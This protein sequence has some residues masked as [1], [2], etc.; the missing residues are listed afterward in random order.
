MDYNRLIDL[1]TNLLSRNT[2]FYSEAFIGVRLIA[3]ICEYSSFG[4]PEAALHSAMLKFCTAI[5]ASHQRNNASQ[6]LRALLADFQ[7]CNPRFN[8]LFPRDLKRILQVLSNQIGKVKLLE[9]ALLA[10]Y[11]T[12]LRLQ[13]YLPFVQL[14]QP[15]SMWDEL[16]RL[17]YAPLFRGADPLVP[18]CFIGTILRSC[19]YPTPNQ[20]AALMANPIA[21]W[22]SPTWAVLRSLLP[23]EHLAHVPGFLEKAFAK[24]RPEALDLLEW[25][26]CGPFGGAKWEPPNPDVPPDTVLRYFAAYAATTARMPLLAQRALE[27]L[28]PALRDLAPAYCDCLLG[29]LAESLPDALRYARGMEEL[30]ARQPDLEWPAHVQR[31]LPELALRAVKG[32]V[33]PAHL[34]AA[35]EFPCP[36]PALMARLAEINHP[37]WRKAPLHNTVHVGLFNRYCAVEAPPCCRTPLAHTRLCRGLWWL[38]PDRL[39]VAHPFFFVTRHAGCQAPS[40]A[41]RVEALQECLLKMSAS[42]L[43]NLKAL[44]EKARAAPHQ[45]SYPH[46]YFVQ[47]AQ[48]LAQTAPALVKIIPTPDF[49]AKFRTLCTDALSAPTMEV[50]SMHYSDVVSPFV[51]LFVTLQDQCKRLS[52]PLPLALANEAIRAIVCF[53]S[54]PF[55]HFVLLLS[56]SGIMWVQ[57]RASQGIHLAPL[58]AALEKFV[59][60]QYTPECIVPTTFAHYVLENLPPDSSRQPPQHF[61]LF[62]GLLFQRMQLPPVPVLCPEAHDVLGRVT[63]EYSSFF[64]HIHQ[65]KVPIAQLRVFAPCVPNL[66]MSLKH[67]DSVTQTLGILSGVFSTEPGVP[68]PMLGLFDLRGLMRQGPLDRLV[69]SQLETIA[70]IAATLDDIQLC[71]SL[72]REAAIRVQRE[73]QRVDELKLRLPDLTLEQL[74]PAL[75]EL[76]RSLFNPGSFAILRHFAAHRS[77]IFMSLLRDGL[78]ALYPDAIDHPYAVSD[79]GEMTAKGTPLLQS[80]REDLWQILFKS[81]TLTIMKHQGHFAAGSPQEEMAALRGF[82]PDAD[83]KESSLQLVEE[84]VWFLSFYS[85]ARFI[86]QVFQQFRIRPGPDAAQYQ[87]LCELV[88]ALPEVINEKFQYDPGMGKAFRDLLG[89]GAPQLGQIFSKLAEC[90]ALHKWMMEMV[91][92]GP[93]WRERYEAKRTMVQSRLRQD[94]RNAYDQ[95]VIS[96]LNEWLPILAE[97]FDP[98]RHPMECIGILRE[99]LQPE[100]PQFAGMLGR[101]SNVCV[102][103]SQ[104]RRWFNNDTPEQHALGLMEDLTQGALEL[105]FN[106]HGQSK[107]IGIWHP[108]EGQA[109]SVSELEIVDMRRHLRLIRDS[110][111]RPAT[112]ALARLRFAQPFLSCLP[113]HDLGQ[114]PDAQRRIEDFIQKHD[115]VSLIR[116][117]AQALAKDGHPRL[118]NARLTISLSKLQPD[119]LQTI[120]NNGQHANISWSD[121][122]LHARA[123]HPYLAF[124]PKRDLFRLAGFLNKRQYAQAM[125]LLSLV[126]PHQG[127]LRPAIE[128][129]LARVPFFQELVPN[130]DQWVPDTG[131]PQ[132]YSLQIDPA[133]RAAWDLTLPAG[134]MLIKTAEACGDFLLHLEGA[135]QQT[136]GIKAL[137]FRPSQ[138]GRGFATM[139]HQGQALVLMAEACSPPRN[140]RLGR[141][142]CGL[143]LLSVLLRLYPERLPEHSDLLWCGPETTTEALAL[144]FERAEH[145]TDRCYTVIHAGRLPYDLQKILLDRCSWYYRNRL[146]AAPGAPDPRLV[147]V[148]TADRPCSLS[149]THL[150]PFVEY[151]PSQRLPEADLRARLAESRRPFDVECVTG[152]AGNGKTYHI[153]RNAPNC[154]T[155]PI[156]EDF[157]FASAVEALATLQAKGDD[158]EHYIHFNISGYADMELVNAFF[159]H[160]LVLHAVSDLH[161][162]QCFAMRPAAA[163]R[164]HFL[165]EI[166]ATMQPRVDE[167]PP[168]CGSSVLTDTEERGPAILRDH[169]PVLHLATPSAQLVNADSLP[170]DVSEP[171][172]ALVCKYLQGKRFLADASNPDRDIVSQVSA[173][174][175]AAPQ[176]LALL[177]KYLPKKVQREIPALGGSHTELRGDLVKVDQRHC[178]ALL[179]HKIRLFERWVDRFEYPEAR[180]I[181]IRQFLDEIR[182]FSEAKLDQANWA[183]R[184]FS[185]LLPIEEDRS[186]KLQYVHSGRNPNPTDEE[187]TEIAR[188]FIER[189]PRRPSGG[190]LFP[191]TKLAGA[192]LSRAELIELVARPLGVSTEH[193]TA[194]LA[195]HNYVLTMDFAMKMIHLH[196]RAL[197]GVT[198]IIEGDT[199]VGKTKLCEVWA[200][201]VNGLGRRFPLAGFMEY[202]AGDILPAIHRLQVAQTQKPDGGAASVLLCSVEDPQPG[203]WVAVP[204]TL[205]EFARHFAREAPFKLFAG[206]LEAGAPLKELRADSPVPVGAG[207]VVYAL[208]VLPTEVPEAHP[209]ADLRRCQED[210]LSARLRPMFRREHPFAKVIGAACNGYLL[211]ALS[212]HEGRL[213]LLDVDDGH[214]ARARDECRDFRGIDDT[215]VRCGRSRADHAGEPAGYDGTAD[216]LDSAIH[217]DLFKVDSLAALVTSA[218]SLLS[219]S[220]LDHCLPLRPHG[221]VF[222]SIGVHGS[223][224]RDSLRDAISAANQ[225]ALRRSYLQVAVFLDEINTTRHEGYVKN[226]LCDR[227][228]DDGVPLADNLFLVAACNPV[229]RMLNTDQ[230]AA[231]TQ[232]YETGYNVHPLALSAHLLKLNYGRLNKEQETEYLGAMFAMAQSDLI[233][234]LEERAEMSSFARILHEVHQLVK[235]GDWETAE[236]ERQLSD[237]D[238][239]LLAQCRREGKPLPDRRILSQRDFQRTLRLMKFFQG[240]FGRRVFRPEQL[241][242]MEREVARDA[243]EAEADL[244]RREAAQRDGP[245]A[246]LAMRPQLTLEKRLAQEARKAPPPGGSVQQIRRDSFLLALSM[247]YYFCLSDAEQRSVRAVVSRYLPGADLGKILADQMDAFLANFNYGKGIAQTWAI[248]ENVF[249]SIVCALTRTPLIIQGPPGASKTLSFERVRENLK[250]PYSAHDDWRRYPALEAFIYQCSKASRNEEVIAIFER[251]AQAQ[252]SSPRSC[253]CVFMDEAGLPER[254]RDSLKVLHYQLDH[255]QCAFIAVT[256]VPLDAAKTNRAV[257]VFRR[258]LQVGDYEILARGVLGYTPPHDLQDD[259][260]NTIKR[261]CQA[262]M[263]LARCPDEHLHK[264]GQRDF[265]N[266]LR[267]LLVRN[268][269]DGMVLGQLGPMTPQS[270]LQSL[271]R[272]YG[273]LTEAEFGRL[274]AHFFRALEWGTFL[275]GPNRVVPSTSI[276][277]LARS[278]GD[279]AV[280]PD[281]FRARYKLVIDESSD[282]HFFRECVLPKVATAGRK[283]ALL[284]GSDF[285][286]DAR[287]EDWRAEQVTSIKIMIEKGSLIVLSGLEC[288]YEALYDV[289]NQRFQRIRAPG[290]ELE[291]FAAI[292]LGSFVSYVRVHPKAQFVIQVPRAKLGE[293]PVP[294]LDRFEKFAVGPAPLYRAQLAHLGDDRTSIV[295]GALKKVRSFVAHVGQE[296][297]FMLNDDTIYSAIASALPYGGPDHPADEAFTTF[298]A[299]T[300]DPCRGLPIDGVSQPEVQARTVARNTMP[301]ESLFLCR[302]KLPAIFSTLY[303][304][305]QEHFSLNRLAHKALALQAAGQPACSRYL[306]FGRHSADLLDVNAIKESLKLPPLAAQ[307]SL[308]LDALEWSSS[309]TMAASFLPRDGARQHDVCVVVCDMDRISPQRVNAIRHA[310]RPLP[311]RSPKVTI[312]LLLFRPA[313]ARPTPAAH[314][315]PPVAPA[316][317][318][319]PMPCDNSPSTTRTCPYP[320]VFLPTWEHVFLD[321]CSAKCGVDVQE[322]IRQACGGGRIITPAPGDDGEGD[323]DD[324]AAL[325]EADA[326]RVIAPDPDPTAPPAAAAAAAAQA[327]PAPIPAAPVSIARVTPEAFQ[328]AIQTVLTTIF[329][330]KPGAK[331]PQNAAI[332]KAATLGERLRHI[333]LAM[334]DL[335]LM[336]TFEAHWTPRELADCVKCAATDLLRH[337]ARTGLGETLG[338]RYRNELVKFLGPVLVD[339]ARHG[340]LDALRARVVP[341]EIKDALWE[342]CFEF[343]LGKPL[344]EKTLTLSTADIGSLGHLPTFPFFHHLYQALEAAVRDIIRETGQDVMHGRQ[345]QGDGQVAQGGEGP[346]AAAQGEAPD[347]GLQRA[348][349]AVVATRLQERLPALVPGELLAA[350]AAHPNNWDSLVFRHLVDNLLYRTCGEEDTL[351]DLQLE[352][353]CAWLRV[354]LPNPNLA[355]LFVTCATERSRLSSMAASVRAMG[356]LEQ[357]TVPLDIRALQIS[358]RSATNTDA[359]MESLRNRLAEFLAQRAGAIFREKPAAVVPWMQALRAVTE[360]AWLDARATPQRDGHRGLPTALFVLRRLEVVAVFY[361]NAEPNPGQPTATEAFR[362]AFDERAKTRPALLELALDAFLRA[363]TAPSEQQ[364]RLFLGELLSSFVGDQFLLG[365][366]LN[367]DVLPDPFAFLREEVLT[368]LR[369]VNNSAEPCARCP[370]LHRALSPEQRHFLVEELLYPA[371]PAPGAGALNPDDQ[372]APE[373][374]IKGQ[375]QELLTR[376]FEVPPHGMAALPAAALPV[377]VPPW[378]L[379]AQP[380]QAS[381]L[382]GWPLAQVLYDLMMAHRGAASPLGDTLNSLQMQ[383]AQLA[384]GR[385]AP[386]AAFGAVQLAVLTHTAATTAARLFV[387]ANQERPE[388]FAPDE[389]QRLAE[390]MRPVEWAQVAFLGQISQDHTQDE[391]KV[392]FSERGAQL[393]PWIDRWLPA[394]TNQPPPYEQLTFMHPADRS[395]RGQAY[396]AFRAAFQAALATGQQAAVAQALVSR[397]DKRETLMFLALLVY[398]EYTR[399]GLQDSPPMALLK[400]ALQGRALERLFSDPKEA[401]VLRCLLDPA[402][403]AKKLEVTVQ[404]GPPSEDRMHALWMDTRRP[405]RH[406]MANLLAV[407][408]GCP[409]NNHL[410]MQMFAPEQMEGRWCVAFTIPDKA[411]LPATPYHFDCGC[412]TSDDQR[413]V[414]SPRA[415]WNSR[416]LPWGM[417]TAYAALG[418]SMLFFN[419]D[420][421][422][423]P[424]RAEGNIISRWDILRAGPRGYSAMHVAYDWGAIP[425]NTPDEVMVRFNAILERL[426]DVFH[427]GGQALRT[428]LNSAQER[429]A[430][431]RLLIERAVE[432]VLS[433]AGLLEATQR[434]LQQRPVDLD[435]VAAYCRTVPQV[436][437]R[438]P[439]DPEFAHVIS[440]SLQQ[441]QTSRSFDNAQ[442]AI[443]AATGTGHGDLLGAILKQ[444][445]HLQALPELLPVVLELQEFVKSRLSNV[446]SPQEAS[447]LTVKKILQRS[448]QLC[449]LASSHPAPS[450]LRSLSFVVGPALAL[451][452]GPMPIRPHS[453][454]RVDQEHGDRAIRLWGAL[455]NSEY[456]RSRRTLEVVN[457]AHGGGGEAHFFPPDEESTFAF[458]VGTPEADADDSGFLNLLAKSLVDQQNHLLALQQGL[459]R[460]PALPAGTAGAAELE[461]VYALRARFVNDSAARVDLSR[462]ISDPTLFIGVPPLAYLRRLCGGFGPAVPGLAH[463]ALVLAQ[464]WAHKPT[465]LI[466]EQPF[467]FR[468]RG[469]VRLR[470]S[471]DRSSSSAV[472][473]ISICIDGPALER[474]RPEDL[475]KLPDA[476]KAPL[477]LGLTELLRSAFAGMNEDDRQSTLH[478]YAMLVSQLARQ[479]AAPRDGAQEPHEPFEAVA[480]RTF[481]EYTRDPHSGLEMDCDAIGIKLPILKQ[482]RMRHVHAL[483]QLADELFGSGPGLANIPPAFSLPL[484]EGAPIE[485]LLRGV[486]KDDLEAISATLLDALASL[487]YLP[488]PSADQ[489]KPDQPLLTVLAQIGE[490]E[491]A[492]HVHRSLLGKHLAAFVRILGRAAATAENGIDR[493]VIGGPPADE[494]VLV[495]DEGGVGLVAEP[496]APPPDLSCA[497]RIR[498]ELNVDGDQA[499]PEVIYRINGVEEHPLALRQGAGPLTWRLLFEA[500]AAQDLGLEMAAHRVNCSL[501]PAHPELPS[502]D[503]QDMK[504]DDT[505]R[506]LLV[507][508]GHR[509]VL[510]LRPPLNT[511]SR[512]CAYRIGGGPEVPLQSYSRAVSWAQLVQILNSSAT[513]LATLARAAPLLGGPPKVTR[514]LCKMITPATAVK[515]CHDEATRIIASYQGAPA[516]QQQAIIVS[517]N[518]TM[519]RL[520]EETPRLLRLLGSDPALAQLPQTA[521]LKQATEAYGQAAAAL[522]AAPQSAPEQAAAQAALQQLFGAALQA[523]QALP[524]V[525]LCFNDMSPEQQR[526]PLSSEGVAFRLDVEL[527]PRVAGCRMLPACTMCEIQLPPPLYRTFPHAPPSH[528]GFSSSSCAAISFRV[529]SV[530]AEA[531]YVLSGCHPD[532]KASAAPDTERSL[533]LPA[534]PGPLRHGDLIQAIRAD[535]FLAGVLARHQKDYECRLTVSVQD[536]WAQGQPRGPEMPLDERVPEALVPLPADRPSRLRIKATWALRA[537][538]SAIQVLLARD[539]TWATLDPPIPPLAPWRGGTWGDLLPLLLAHPTIRSFLDQF[540]A[541]CPGKVPHWKPLFADAQRQYRPLLECLAEPLPPY[542][543]YIGVLRCVPTFAVNMLG[544]S[545]LPDPQPVMGPGGIPRPLTWRFAVEHCDRNVAGTEQARVRQRY[546]QYYH[547]GA[548]QP[549]Q[550]P[551]GDA[552]SEARETAPIRLE[553][554]SLQLDPANPRACL[555]VTSRSPL[556]I[557]LQFFDNVQVTVAGVT[558][559]VTMLDSDYGGTFQ[560]L[561]AKLAQ[562]GA[563]GLEGLAHYLLNG[564]AFARPFRPTDPLPAGIQNGIALS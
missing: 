140:H 94:D 313:L 381:S 13:S 232:H 303:L 384:E 397:P 387:G 21:E 437:H 410:W 173:L 265:I 407:I 528:F 420:S 374:G 480:D 400:A 306:V 457:C 44:D 506:P 408:L 60:T 514:I 320:I 421:A 533:T 210:A 438:K 260:A 12:F 412:A 286:Q 383:R 450:T 485:D 242:A 201:L 244:A 4:L 95:R 557:S 91:F 212:P 436:R 46:A 349:D 343:Y 395:P 105:Q 58:F 486:P 147:V 409:P 564:Q 537:G 144:F 11:A 293:I 66:G 270:V 358:L 7:S 198:T 366:L 362:V 549:Y 522:N 268:P 348:F 546:V 432:P 285:P 152:R 271:E 547:Q 519:R 562:A 553:G 85:V 368:V 502:G 3:K 330:T 337:E 196:E 498:K 482:Q 426:L 406:A 162:A 414:Y 263:D 104:I 126:F 151:E 146:Q 92:V 439:P 63:T 107:L 545:A 217:A 90:P 535:G 164:W 27:R 299:F 497:E 258:P 81:D 423:G 188:I 391:I 543:L 48:L 220:L 484:P 112:P 137:G 454:A 280:S 211:G 536:L 127:N 291:E 488:R 489:L 382:S 479:A 122:F 76:E 133:D 180:V 15:I 314:G 218:L 532:D 302:T 86:P 213:R 416:T 344:R 121:D 225:T 290:G 491:L 228:L 34:K 446:L 394:L 25:L 111:V 51:R 40:Q 170:Y 189:P 505:A 89:R 142:C 226:V 8:D 238:R 219:L 83:M 380:D 240:H 476:L 183:A 298:P 335:P 517:Y 110:Q 513:E 422:G 492:E 253:S 26:G 214:L 136:P 216:L 308:V 269:Q 56:F 123:A 351:S 16:A 324:E 10:G 453:Y 93:D 300:E 287:N 185:Q 186:V 393:S 338:M 82:F 311:N 472:A 20:T 45:K 331:F 461:Q 98:A 430:Y 304:S 176:A 342:P 312:L 165:V 277:L 435:A 413:G 360:L 297:F 357:A 222:R 124:L 254:S 139:P 19:D 496:T 555:D 1:I 552:E 153:R 467:Q 365:P 473:S 272:H 250:G 334:A 283:V 79:L 223:L 84:I 71:L 108:A 329:W 284:L 181:V 305:G 388:R 281:G 379:A 233:F 460:P 561:L 377:F 22:V 500:I 371:I 141:P 57:A 495:W 531:S 332:L 279:E 424:L 367:F 323:D 150:V 474:L 363:L 6:D 372:P 319:K 417:M 61:G 542:P 256:N 554:P 130:L 77:A 539:A 103:V 148:Q 444:H 145:H 466:S 167:V 273:G 295:E 267:S 23:I 168:E 524:E 194:I 301:P 459:L 24:W 282:D 503:Y 96:D 28:V 227:I 53:R 356:A 326:E 234:P 341:Q 390:L 431:E 97:A 456:L 47:L 404:G 415:P 534:T 556:A 544:A 75:S 448:V 35:A 80:I 475:Q 392:V 355:S 195:E 231:G 134:N 471:G 359:I 434:R 333:Q 184:H 316:N 289:F 109:I 38:P 499:A 405:V 32:K 215:C 62:F 49:L 72:C 208:P 336:K 237:E 501:E 172:C 419:H 478:G 199:G 178:I 182:Q 259:A 102:S 203:R 560:T 39:D 99:R 445:P 288:L 202:F 455:L 550:G 470:T 526:A 68:L 135:L 187:A 120:I 193:A 483:A 516:D 87:R 207:W 18:A 179:A 494:P 257:L 30:H 428:T 425:A 33:T 490:E 396:Q 159:F 469:M 442:V 88:D 29:P 463:L 43:A 529:I 310:L 158:A 354:A 125:P 149:E 190:V 9:G 128:A 508:R 462:G 59:V 361:R 235:K 78:K 418:M 41:H 70:A 74:L 376:C 65:L 386:E 192:R 129:A 251:A 154:V 239:A 458:L 443:E 221:Q 278:L 143:D 369:L 52:A 67:P 530:R 166:P 318:P 197:S 451:V 370:L 328:K 156:L 401:T 31:R 315:A 101:L 73:S 521:Q 261:L 255:P 236:R 465:F 229:S 510:D 296:H 527:F 205:A 452:P 427:S 14:G 346:E 541:D 169:L 481:E 347:G 518:E 511:Q 352:V 191:T 54:L 5:H 276:D 378:R 487:A 440:H 433:D 538:A 115:L 100:T 37:D 309:T 558:R 161:S 350:L 464:R 385:P 275:E 2:S 512:D 230:R 106:L 292:A 249:V 224:T 551:A 155:I 327:V 274:L 321:E 248:K 204:A 138:A 493:P 64:W 160:L 373:Q 389:L 132:T 69:K 559:T 449:P 447:R 174:E 468:A 353:L 206:P 117:A 17:A 42:C 429:D 113:H 118:Q 266:F 252:R 509:L 177:A 131:V 317:A 262:H 163:P 411:I 114:P 55:R 294:F 375:L 477:E 264:F 441:H 399:K 307:E 36:P 515:A 398:H 345:A 119:H 322:W 209:E 402:Q 247:S 157:Q 116:E 364:C 563:P 241:E 245:H 548:W 540:A 523:A 243:Q 403:L 504:P 171:N 525:G 340:D 507:P 246:P 50:F 325:G 175:V 200:H 339:L 520:L